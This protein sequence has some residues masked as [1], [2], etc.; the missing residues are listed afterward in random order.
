MRCT[1][2]IATLLLGACLH[3]QQNDAIIK[4]ICRIDITTLGENKLKGLLL[5]TSDSSIV[6]YPGKRKQ[7][8]NGTKFKPVEFTASRIKRITVKKNNRALKGMTIGSVVGALPMLTGS[9]DGNTAGL[10]EL[11]KLSMP[12][13]GVTGALLGLTQQRSFYINGSVTLF[14]E[15]QISIK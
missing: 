1:T 9:K 14:R 8:N 15:F 5:Y 12:V 10:Q 13:G 4:P 7:W 11:T 2:T 6:V 3:A